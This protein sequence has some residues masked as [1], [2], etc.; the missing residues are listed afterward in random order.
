METSI[1]DKTFPALSIG[2]EEEIQKEFVFHMALG[3]VYSNIRLYKAGLLKEEKLG[4]M[5]GI[6]YN[7]PWTRDAAINTWN[8]GGLLFPEVAKNTLLSTLT[9]DTEGNVIIGGQYWDKVI[10]AVGAW[11]YYLYTGDKEMLQLAYETT[12]RTLQK[13][14]KEEFDAS[15]NLFRGP[16]VYGDGVAAYP[17]VYTRS[18]NNKTYSAISDWPEENPDLRSK[19]GYGIPMQSLSTNILYYRVYQILPEM[20]KELDKKG[21][22][23]WDEKA[24]RLKE[25]INKNFWNPEK[26]TYNYFLGPFGGSEAQEGMGISFA[27]MFGVADSNQTEALFENTLVEPAGIPVVWPSYPRYINDERTS[28]GRHSGTVW[29]HV[30]GFWA[31]A[32]ALNNR[33]EIFLYEFNALTNNVWRDKQFV[34]IYHPKSGAKYGGIQENA[35]SKWNLTH[36][37]NRQTWSATAYLRMILMGVM[38][39]RFDADGIE[40]EPM[41]PEGM[42]S[43][44]LENLRYRDALLNLTIEGSGDRIA[45]FI[46]NG[47]KTNAFIPSDIE[48]LQRIEIKMEKA[49]N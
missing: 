39:M 16:A 2:N 4:F 26:Q 1:Y 49:G 32:A 18:V 40:F 19:V 48:G 9:R 29:P 12:Q 22:P 35:S 42:G 44:H 46:I 31:H 7:K 47:K 11:N 17:K 28:Y 30:Q 27:I 25:A 37:Q 45:S 10:W 20:A 6:N 8:G 34:E 14:E 21:N 36:S 23:E 15:N 5:A 41:L 38:G 3:D 24:K 33:K 13:M 43:I